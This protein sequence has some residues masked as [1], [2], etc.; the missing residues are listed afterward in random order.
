MLVLD[1]LSTLEHQRGSC[2]VAF[3]LARHF[4]GKPGFQLSLQARAEN[5]A[6]IL[7]TLQCLKCRRRLRCHTD[8][9]VRR[10]AHRDDAG[11]KLTIKVARSNRLAINNQTL[12]AHQHGRTRRFGALKHRS[13]VL[14]DSLGHFIG[15]PG[16]GERR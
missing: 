14:V 2:A 11:R 15:N 16:I 5:A 9:F 12:S 13:D 1:D 8:I 10:R 4:L 3:K 7:A 6:V